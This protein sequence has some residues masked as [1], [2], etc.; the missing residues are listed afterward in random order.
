MRSMFSAVMDTCA[1]EVVR[2]DNALAY[3]S[4]SEAAACYVRLRAS[5][6]CAVVFRRDGHVVRSRGSREKN[7]R[8]Q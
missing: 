7:A 6:A 8:A 5:G 2:A 4:D 1:K 3:S